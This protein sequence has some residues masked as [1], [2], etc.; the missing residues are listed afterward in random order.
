MTKYKVVSGFC[1]GGVGDVYPGTVVELNQR[2][3]ARE[4]HNGRVIEYV[5]DLDAATSTVAA[6]SVARVEATTS[7]KKEKV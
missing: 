6:S 3:A 5:E 2:D 1:L 4:L 7:R